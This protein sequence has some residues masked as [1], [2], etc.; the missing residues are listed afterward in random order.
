MLTDE[1]AL[2]CQQDQS[3]KAVFVLTSKHQRKKLWYLLG[4]YEVELKKLSP[5]FLNILGEQGI[6]HASSCMLK[7]LPY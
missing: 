6:F 2:H 7:V 4:A 3:F 1:M 5:L